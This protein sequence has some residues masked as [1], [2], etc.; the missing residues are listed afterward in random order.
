[1]KFEVV[2][3]VVKFMMGLYE[4]FIKCDCFIVEINL[5][6]VIKEG[7]VFCLDVKMNFDLMLLL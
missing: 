7:D 6:V 5:F 1:M 3:K 4:V 2:N